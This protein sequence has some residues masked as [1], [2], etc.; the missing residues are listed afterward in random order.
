[1]RETA[2]IEASQSAPSGGRM[3]AVIAVFVFAGAALLVFS[4]GLRSHWVYD[5]YWA[6]VE[7]PH[8]RTLWPLSV[9]L[10]AEQ[11][12]PFVD[13]PIVSLTCAINYALAGGTADSFPFRVTNVSIHVINALLLFGLIRRTFA[14]PR[15]PE[16]GRPA[17]LPIAF[18]AALLWLV[19][20]F[21]VE[22]VIYVTQRTELMFATFLLLTLYAFA[23]AAVSAGA[24]GRA[25]WMLVSVASCAL[26]MACKEVMISAPLVVLLFDRAYVSGGFGAA[27][28]RHRGLYAGLVAAWGL[29]AVLLF[30]E[31]NRNLTAGFDQAIGVW[32][33]LRI[34]AGVLLHYLKLLVYAGDLNVHYHRSASPA[35]TQWL[36]QG[37]VI[38]VL[39]A[40]A[41]IATL[42]RP[43]W[44]TPALAAF[45]VLA[46][47]SS[48]YPIE[49]E[50]G[51]DRRMYVP[52]AWLLVL[53]V[54]AAHVVL[55][56][57]GRAAARAVVVL[58]LVIGG[59]F[60]IQ[61]YLRAEEWNDPIGIWADGIAKTPDDPISHNN[62]AYELSSRRG[63]ESREA[64]EEAIAHFRKAIELDPTY[65]SAHANLAA[66]Y[67]K[68]GELDLALPLLQKA[69]ELDP[70]LADAHNNAGVLLLMTGEY[71]QALKAFTIAM[72]LKPRDAVTHF[73]RADALYHLG[74]TDEGIA[75]IQ[76][77]LELGLD[78]KRPEAF[79][80]LGDL[81]ADR[82][83]TARAMHFYE[84]A[85]AARPHFP[86]V[87][88]KMGMLCV[89]RNDTHAAR[90]FFERAVEQDPNN[91]QARFNLAMSY[92]RMQEWSKAAASLE[93]VLRLD[94]NFSAARTQLERVRAF[95]ARDGAAATP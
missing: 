70:S 95:Q 15:V 44:G 84:Q 54:A 38:V 3:V 4:P 27:L 9:P 69:V 71:E 59:Y 21:S 47:T 93:T 11:E 90:Q 37:I 64:T 57:R 34:Q 24:I 79:M 68:T 13:R 80:R 58:S 8:V 67:L 26:G 10:S 46:P 63:E 28:R 75:A 60:G 16:S 33:Y 22:P 1:M 86:T 49:T 7:N 19:H 74:R 72:K 42:R 92:A 53:F 45:I 55:R 5:D 2:S 82:G 62:Y 14:L 18:G 36:P 12:A 76:S 35:V 88:F 32:D 78:Q 20:P 31:P 87:L 23:R 30:T 56:R 65:A 61:S 52:A 17:G 51:S 25:G 85:L 91:L 89:S 83:D 81:Y 29:L 48:F 73:N 40:G 94:P 41:I 50:V 66:V 6:I 39:L 43:M 77:A